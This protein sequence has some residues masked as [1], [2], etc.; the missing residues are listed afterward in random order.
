MSLSPDF[1]KDG[2]EYGLFD[3]YS[4]ILNDKNFYKAFF[5]NLKYT[6]SVLLIVI[7]LSL[8]LSQALSKLKNQKLKY[9]YL[10]CLLLPGLIPPSIMGILFNLTF[11]G[12]TGILNQLFII[13]FGIRP[14]DWMKDPNFIMTSLVIQAVWRWLGFISLF[15]LCALESVPKDIKEA[16]AIDGAG[17]LRRFL[18]IELPSI[19]HVIIFCMAFLFVDTISLFSGSYSLLGNSGGTAN[20]GLV[21]SNYSYGFTSFR[22]YN[23]ASTV[24]IMIL[25]VLM[26]LTGFFCLRKE[27]K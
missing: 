21:L 22:Q 26:L 1:P 24:S 14:I 2:V 18:S 16:A 8:V 13:P 6:S 15:M 25:P 27:Q 10:F 23:L 17:P 5:N 11:N 12:K 7:P 3:N 19:K 20:A 4:R 9:F